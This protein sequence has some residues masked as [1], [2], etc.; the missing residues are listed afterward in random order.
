MSLS[1]NVL[2]GNEQHSMPRLVSWDLQSQ[3]NRGKWGNKQVKND[4]TFCMS[5]TSQDPT[6]GTTRRDIPYIRV[7]YIY[8]LAEHTH[9]HLNLLGILDG[10]RGTRPR[11]PLRGG[12]LLP[13]LPVGDPADPNDRP[14]GD[15][16]GRFP[17]GDCCSGLLS[18]P[19]IKFLSMTGLQQGNKTEVDIVQM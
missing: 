7:L 18:G 3:I 16:D 1:H 2:G 10:R 11:V 9:H 4:V 13:G 6:Q 15:P 5:G 17:S 14:P 12:G 8:N 19:R